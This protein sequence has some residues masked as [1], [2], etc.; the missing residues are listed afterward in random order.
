MKKKELIKEI[1]KALDMPESSHEIM[2]YVRKL[3]EEEEC[4]ECEPKRK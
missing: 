4:D 1:K 2:K 3:I